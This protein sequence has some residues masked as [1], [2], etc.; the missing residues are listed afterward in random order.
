MVLFAF[1]H[2]QAMDKNRGILEE[3][4]QFYNLIHLGVL[5]FMKLSRLSHLFETVLSASG[6]LGFSLSLFCDIL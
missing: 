1:E 5:F 2:I 4:V 3:N 6:V